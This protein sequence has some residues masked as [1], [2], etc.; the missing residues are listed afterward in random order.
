VARAA[1]DLLGGAYGR[2]VVVL[3]GTGNNGADGRAAARRLEARG[4]RCHVV[5]AA[6]APAVLPRADLVIDAAYGTG[7]RGT[8]TPPRLPAGDP[9][10]LA[11]DIPSGVSGLTG[12]AAGDPWP[13]VATVTFAAWKPGLLLADGPEL[14]GHVAVVDIGLD[15]SGAR[16]HRVTAADMAAW[17]PERPRS[18][19]KW[20]AA[21]RI[22]AGSPGMTGAA[23]LATRA[24]QRSG[25]GYVRLSTP[26]S[27]SDPLAPTEAV[28]TALPARR[29]ADD[30][31]DGI[32]R[33][34]ALAVGPGLGT[35]EGTASE[36]R[37]LVAAC[38][39]P[40]VVDGD[41][42]SALGD[43]AAEV[44][45]SRAEGAGPVVLTPHDGEFARL[46]GGP[47]GP[48]R[49]EAVRRLAADTGAVVLLK[50]STTLV[51]EPGGAVLAVTEGDARLATA[52]TGDVLTG[53]VAALLARG[54]P[55]ARA[56]AAG[57]LLHGRAGALAWP[58]GL[59][60]GDLVDHLPA[61]LAELAGG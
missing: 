37:R 27:E 25:A 8:F 29:W 23:H 18:T 1:L 48:D 35:G 13:A 41:G 38:A 52:G 54:M 56:A 26:G 4:V 9:P 10:V 46:T 5:D 24:A 51:A 42:L 60:A 36:V 57:A 53:I 34:G 17:L 22:V 43:R 14:A 3:A 47:P 11:V 12:E 39:V 2:R 59:V 61:A 6:D 49:F 7:F 40:T 55:A 28:V 58:E 20:K 16:G 45:R 31:L 19:H 15:L 44:V 32:D 33:F 30:A 21:V 50:G